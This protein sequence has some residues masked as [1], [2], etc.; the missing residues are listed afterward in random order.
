MNGS[1]A[2]PVYF[3]SGLDNAWLRDPSREYSRLA[4]PREFERLSHNVFRFP[5][6]FHPPVVRRLIHRFSSPG[7]TVLDPFCGSGTTLVEG[8]VAGRAVVGTDIDPLSVLITRAKIQRYDIDYLDALARGLAGDLARMRAADEKLWSGFECEISSSDYAAASEELSPH[9]PAIPNIEHWFRRRVIVQLAAIKAR[10]DRHRGTPAHLFFQLCF[11]SIIRNASNADPVPVSGLEV[12]KHMLQRELHGRAVDPYSL[13]DA[14]LRK[15]I[16]AMRRFRDQRAP[17]ILGR[18]ARADVRHL[19]VRGTGI[20]DCVITS[21][22]YLT[23]VDY[24]RRHT[25]ETFW[26]GLT[27]TVAERREIKPRYL[28]HDRL[29]ER[30]AANVDENHGTEIGRRWL[31]RLKPVKPERARAFLHYCSGMSEALVRFTEI[32][33]ASKP[34]VLVVGNVRFCGAHISM[35]DL[36]TQL[37]APHLD[38]VDRLW[39]PLV[40]RYMS[41]ERK[42]GADIDVDHVLIFRSRS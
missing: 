38:L 40:N 11:V 18:C 37:A 9:I 36:L 22:P 4:F 16:E 34:I 41:Y 8:L 23:A 2:I 42:H 5:A 26:L 28:G 3:G 19:S 7:Q 6:K 39:Y 20:V 29:G 15:A 12:T 14:A 21:P 17:G 27:A 24:Y 33:R 25:L 30:Q 35:P 1:L 13:L 32:V 31:A 10:M